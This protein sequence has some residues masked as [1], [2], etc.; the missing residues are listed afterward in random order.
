LG[1][2]QRGKHRA[3]HGT[4]PLTPLKYFIWHTF[5]QMCR[6]MCFCCQIGD[7]AL[8]NGNSQTLFS[9]AAPPFKEKIDFSKRQNEE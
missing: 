9:F 2:C 1:A 4:S 5:L 8:S 6:G 7:C 3:G